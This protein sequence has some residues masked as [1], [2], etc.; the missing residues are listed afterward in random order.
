[1]YTDKSYPVDVWHFLILLDKKWVEFA[2]FIG[3]SKEEVE[4]IVSS[5][6]NSV[7]EQIKNFLKVGGCLT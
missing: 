7:N 4:T 2:L 1:M 5:A 6:P 3:Y